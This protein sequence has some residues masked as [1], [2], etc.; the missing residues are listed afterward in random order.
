MPPRRPPPSLL[1]AAMLLPALLAGCRRADGPV[2]P[3]APVVLVSIDTLR[4][5]RLPLY[6]SGRVATPAIDSLAKDAIVFDDARAHYPLTLPSHVS[7]LTGL[8]PPRH[9]VRDNLGYTLDATAHPTLARWLADSGY[10]TGAFVS[11]YVLRAATG[12]GSSFDAWDGPDTLGPETLLDLV[13]RPGTATV[14]AARAWIDRHAARPFFLFVH[15][16]EPHAPYTPPEPYRSRYADPYD[17]EIATA[18]A[19][20]GEL[21]DFLRA[22]GLYERAAIALVSDHGEGLGEHGELRHGVFLYRS[23]LHVPLL[24]KLPGVSSAGRRVAAPVG[25][26]DVAPTLARLAGARPPAGLDGR[27]LLA[28]PA[29]DRVLYAE[30]FYARLHFGW[31]D[32]EAASDGRWSLVDGPAPELFDL[33]ADPGETASVLERER[34]EF[35][36]LRSAIAATRRPLAAPES[37]TRETAAKLAALGYLTGTAATDAELPDPRGQRDVLADLEAGLEAGSEGRDA[38]AERLLLAVLARND[39]M[40]DVWSALARAY[41]Q[42]GRGREALAAWERVL[43]LSGGDF[44]TALVVAEHS[45]AIGDL[46]RAAAI[47]ESVRAQDPAGYEEMMAEVDLASGRGAS[48]DARMARAVEL[49]SKSEVVRRRLA[50]A[51]LAAKNPQRALELL[52]A[53]RKGAEPATLTVLALALGDAGRNDEALP[54]LEEARRT[55]RPPADFFE[56]LGVALLALDRL[57]RAAAAFE[58]A[59][60]LDPR[61]ASAWNALGVAR[62]R[63]GD[64]RRAID[65][66]RR[67]VELDG[68]Q[69][70]AWYNL[71]LAA[72]QAGDRTLA[73]QA[74]GRFLASAPGTAGA[75][76]ERA[77]EILARLGGGR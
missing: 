29:A 5:D 27:D 46:A 40:R 9:G 15:L 18:D 8:L 56:N 44:A 19:A 37:V 68:S 21:L 7:L 22:R 36:R 38:D 20:L 51:A 31:S 10:A 61:L 66:W 54:L 63:G 4:A 14:A 16:Y 62:F 28:A 59:T 12:L 53:V 24:L 77:R 13:Q 65:A 39:K 1:A 25:L 57:D 67:S 11:S 26:V 64:A 47:A 3:G 52:E 35:A 2:S 43:S 70:D 73:R 45:L 30:T 49:G 32:L 48:A 76:R 75:E 41:D 34:R 58:Q 42:Q 55:A 33:A 74:L 72:A 50:I 17:G 71:G 6:G 69:L 23:T 60:A